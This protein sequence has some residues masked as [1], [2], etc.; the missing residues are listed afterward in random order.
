MALIRV[1]TS[2]EAQN[3]KP[4]P[5]KTETLTRLLWGG[6]ENSEHN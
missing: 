3:L 6:T 1:Y 2:D 4:G 5:G